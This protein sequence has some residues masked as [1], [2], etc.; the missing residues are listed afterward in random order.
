MA[1]DTVSDLSLGE[2]LALKGQLFELRKK[3]N[4]IELQNQQTETFSFR[5]ELVTDYYELPDRE[6]SYSKNVDRA[7]QMRRQ[8]LDML[9][10]TLEFEQSAELTFSP[11][12]TNKSRRIAERVQAQPGAETDVGQR[13][14]NQHARI[15]ENKARQQEI[16]TQFDARTGQRL[17]SPL[18]SA[19][20]KSLV[21]STGGANELDAHEFMYRDAVDRE[22]RLRQQEL[23]SHEDSERVASARKL[24]PQSDRILRQRAE[25]ET[26]ALFEYLD[27]GGS[28][29]LAYDD[30]A[31]AAEVL[32]SRGI[33]RVDS[34][35]GQSSHSVAGRVW[36][37]LLGPRHH[38]RGPAVPD[39]APKKKGAEA[40][41]VF[42]TT[43]R[44]L[45]AGEAEAKEGLTGQSVGLVSFTQRVLPVAARAYLGA[46]FDSFELY[47]STAER[48]AGADEMQ[49][50]LPPA[51]DASAAPSTPPR[52]PYHIP[53]KGPPSATKSPHKF[54]AVVLKSDLP[55]SLI[56]AKTSAV[57]VKKAPLGTTP[58]TPSNRVAAQAQSAAVE[59]AVELSFRSE[60]GDKPVRLSDIP[61]HGRVP[62]P[63]PKHFAPVVRNP[64]EAVM[65]SAYAVFRTFVMALLALLKKHGAELGL[66]QGADLSR[67]REKARAD[68]AQAS[69]HRNHGGSFAPQIPTRS[70]ELAMSKEE[71][72]AAV[73]LQAALAEA[74]PED[75]SEEL[76]GVAFAEN[77]TASPAG[78]KSSLEMLLERTKLSQERKLQRKEALLSE[79]MRECTFQPRINRSQAHRSTG[80]ASSAA[81]LGELKVQTAE[82]DTA[83]AKSGGMDQ[84]S[85]SSAL[86]QIYEYNKEVPAHERLYAMKDKAPRSNRVVH[87]T[88]EELELEQCTFVPKLAPYN[89]SSNPLEGE[90]VRPTGWDEAVSRLRSIAAAR[91]EPQ[92][93]DQVEAEDLDRRYARACKVFAE[94]PKEFEFQVDR[95]ARERADRRKAHTKPRLFVDVKLSASKVANIPVY[96]NDNPAELAR[97]FCKIYSFPREA[98]AVLEEVIRQS[99]EANGVR[100]AETAGEMRATVDG[101]A[102]ADAEGEGEGEADT[103]SEP[104][105]QTEPDVGPDVNPEL[106]TDAGKRVSD[107]ENTA[108]EA[109]P[110]PGA[111]ASAGNIG[112]GSAAP[113]TRPKIRLRVNATARNRSGKDISVQSVVASG[114]ED[115]D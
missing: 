56:S 72:E 101:E 89:S 38:E 32:V 47:D 40:R 29:A 73:L 111:G 98:H 60:D 45:S 87:K 30:I 75:D 39:P 3:L 46:R 36:G 55:R 54:K 7:E 14:Y 31:A 63:S 112:R 15:Q 42:R 22:E 52:S 11:S 44:E 102:E 71:R 17:F 90:P 97:R 18:I 43:G 10:A 41:D 93:T 103:G 68:A 79:E 62:A 86:G 114:G 115:A 19:K 91:L 61:V 77:T 82:D 78:K 95:R 67:I 4:A 83:S 59:S 48:A 74:N 12:I 53:R 28:G 27:R 23:R 65:P 80:P 8:K 24:N 66:G 49:L 5:P 33:L 50:P 21:P 37:V 107:V 100:I 9:K 85:T 25:R 105:P 76:S 51:Q 2:K 26:R 57:S 58:S 64:N 69:A 13:L 113:A 96:D 110:S 94:G 81:S 84:T 35:T 88:K 70:R 99:M 108:N 6:V 104:E 20:S 1:M 92:E 106:G 109:L 34:A 16:I